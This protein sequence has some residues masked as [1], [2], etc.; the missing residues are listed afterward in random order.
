MR[1]GEILT[2]VIVIRFKLLRKTHPGSQIRHV[3]MRQ[4]STA[5]CV[6]VTYGALVER[7]RGKA[8]TCGT[9]DLNS[10]LIWRALPPAGDKNNE[11]ILSSILR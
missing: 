2:C 8:L 3:Q 5:C 9:E 7:A 1:V 4:H 10:I 6:T 11:K